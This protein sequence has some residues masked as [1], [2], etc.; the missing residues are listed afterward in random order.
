MSPHRDGRAD[1]FEALAP[2]LPGRVASLPPTT[3]PYSTALRL[4]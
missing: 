4:D 2:V 3:A 1:L